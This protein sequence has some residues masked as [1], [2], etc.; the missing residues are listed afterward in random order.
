ML[1]HYDEFAGVGGTSEGAS[2]VPG[3]E[4]IFAANHKKQ[5]IA[6]HAANFP[7]AD[8]FDGDV[9]RADITTFPRAD[10]FTA[11]PVC[12]PWSNASQGRLPAASSRPQLNS[13]TASAASSRPRGRPTRCW[14]TR[15]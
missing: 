2:C 12:P 8:H 7:H 14:R 6:S 9:E 13:S 1:T 11:S 4:L 10:I 15:C 3:V 5:A